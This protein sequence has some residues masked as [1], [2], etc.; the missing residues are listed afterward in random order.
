[1]MA[2]SSRPTQDIWAGKHEPVSVVYKFFM[3]PPVKLPKARTRPSV[4]PDVDKLVRSCTDSLTGILY[5]DDGQ[6]VDVSAQKF[7]GVAGKEQKSQ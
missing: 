5:V 7:Y 2:L 6:I 1:M 4:K 3:A